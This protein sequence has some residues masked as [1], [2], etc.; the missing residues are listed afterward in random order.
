MWPIRCRS[1]KRIEDSS[2]PKTMT[3]LMHHRL[4][5]VCGA[6]ADSYLKNTTCSNQRLYREH[7]VIKQI[8]IG[9]A[10]VPGGSASLH[11]RLYAGVRFADLEIFDYSDINTSPKRRGRRK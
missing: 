7:D 2:L 3:Y 9:G 6:D 1:R 4:E 10:L 11:P 5:T 8:S